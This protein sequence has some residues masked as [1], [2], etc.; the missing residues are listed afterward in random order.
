MSYPDF[1][2]IGAQKAGT[3]WL[4]HNL[5]LHPEVWMPPVKELHYFDEKIRRRTNLVSRLRGT[6]PEELRWRRQARSRRATSTGCAGGHA[7]SWAAA[8]GSSAALTSPV[9]WPRTPTWM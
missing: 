9:S 2:G 4:S 1:L 6:E 3:T 8:R 5:Q 7:P